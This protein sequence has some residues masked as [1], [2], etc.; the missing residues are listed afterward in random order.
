[1]K[2]MRSPGRSFPKKMF[3]L[4]LSIFPGVQV[5]TVLLLLSFTAAFGETTKL[6][7]G[8]KI[9]YRSLGSGT[10]P[11]VFIHGYSTSSAFWEKV[12]PRLGGDVK[13]YALDQRGFGASDKPETGYR[14]DDLADDIIGF[15]DALKIEKAVFVGHSMGGSVLQH[16][17]VRNPERILA[18]VLSNAFARTLPPKGLTENVKKRIDGYGDP[19]K[20]RAIF[21]SSMTKYV[22]AANVASGDLDLFINIGLQASNNAL[23]KTLESLY[24]TP[25]LAVEKLSALAVPVLI[26]TA[27]HD[28]FSSFEHSVALTDAFGNSRLVVIPRCGHS[29]MWEKPELFTEALVSFLS[30]YGILK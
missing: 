22:D 3:R 21:Q 25:A 16:L 18:L 10:V 26:V 15:L 2:T 7:D 28:P 5:L 8:T 29:P 27:T 17:A 9:F 24:N 11:L 13:A 23:K 30:S 6:P 12:L 14:L 1:M 19:E 20:N 4:T